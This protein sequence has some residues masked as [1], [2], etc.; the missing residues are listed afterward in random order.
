MFKLMGK[1]IIAI[2]GLIF[3]LLNWP[4]VRAVPE[5]TNRD[6][7]LCVCVWGG[8]GGEV[9][10]CMPRFMMGHVLII[11]L[12]SFDFSIFRLIK[13]TVFDRSFTLCG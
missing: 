5:M 13:G 8:G 12:L 7:V 10:G 4:Y 3:F 9:E 1:K 11:Y 6:V 2:L